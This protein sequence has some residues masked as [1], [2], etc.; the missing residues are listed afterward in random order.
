MPKHS[1]KKA[2]KMHDEHMREPKSVTQ[3]SQNELLKLL[4]RHSREMG[5][6]KKS[7]V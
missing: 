7:R 6:R 1:L 4:K 3:S 2:I 5:K